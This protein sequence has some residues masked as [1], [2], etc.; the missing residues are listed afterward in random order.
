[1]QIK[2]TA[3]IMDV[4]SN[5]TWFPLNKLFGKNTINLTN[6]NI[7]EIC[8]NTQDNKDEFEKNCQ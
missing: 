7:Y 1:M 5:Y 2:I 4:C 3:L 6:A 8:I